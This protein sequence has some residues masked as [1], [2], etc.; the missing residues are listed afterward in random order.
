MLALTRA[1]RA[2]LHRLV[3]REAAWID[4]R[5]AQAL[6]RRGLVTGGPILWS[7]TPEGLRLMV[8]LGDPHLTRAQVYSMF[9]SAA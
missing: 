6:L 1:Q 2:A 4:D 5:T 8:L 7:I 3:D 9:D